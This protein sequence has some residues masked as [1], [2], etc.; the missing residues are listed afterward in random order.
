VTERLQKYMARVGIG[1]RRQCESLIR[2]GRIAVNGVRAEIGMSVSPGRDTVLM[3]GK[4]IGPVEQLV[5][6]ALN[7]PTGV[8]SSRRSQG[9]LPT[10]VDLV[11][12]PARLYPAGRLDADSQGLMV[13]TNDG[14]LTY[15][16]THPKFERE[17]EYRVLLDRTP[18]AAD[19]EA[20]RRGIDVPDLGRTLPADVRLEDGGER[21]YVRVVMREGKNREIRRVAET[22][23]YQVQKLIRVRIGELMLG[24]LREGQ[25]RHLTTD[26]VRSLRGPGARS[27]RRSDAKP[28]GRKSSAGQAG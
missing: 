15:H 11:R 12:V 25:W 9:G 26:E 6:V 3:D 18:G 2:A 20:W 16:L 10:V 7:K 23:G 21:R 24:N 8:L 27:S 19:L 1:S 28:D 4:E 5:Y 17:K 22:L 13:L 14:D